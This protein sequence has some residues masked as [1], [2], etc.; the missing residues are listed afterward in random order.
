MSAALRS[1]VA[2]YHRHSVGAVAQRVLHRAQALL[3]GGEVLVRE[4]I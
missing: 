4:T 2:S 1:D 3:R